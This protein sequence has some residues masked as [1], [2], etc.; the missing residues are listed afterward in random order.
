MQGNATRSVAPCVR[1]GRHGPFG[2]AR[3]VDGFLGEAICRQRYR[4]S[5]LHERQC[6]PALGR[7]NQVERSQLIILAPSAP[8]GQRCLP[9]FVLRLGHERTGPTNSWEAASSESAAAMPM[10]QTRIE[11]ALRI[12]ALMMPPGCRSC[13]GLVRDYCGSVR[14]CSAFHN[15]M[16][17]RPARADSAERTQTNVFDCSARCPEI[18]ALAAARPPKCALDNRAVHFPA[19]SAGQARSC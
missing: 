12:A 6:R 9:G 2:R 5:L 14:R 11:T 19:K 10:E 7:R 16:S 13:P 8:V 3:D 1:S 17:T 4:H 18:D 15:R